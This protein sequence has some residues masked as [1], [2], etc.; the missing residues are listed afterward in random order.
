MHYSKTLKFTDKEYPQ[1]LK[2]VYRPPQ[3]LFYRGNLGIL[4]KPSIAIV[5]T[6]RPT[7]YGEYM[8]EK[9]VKELSVLDVNIVSGLAKGIDTIAHETALECGLSTIAILGSGIENIYPPANIKLAKAIEGNGLVI[10]EFEGSTEPKDF[11]FPMRNRIISGLSLATI[12][13]EAPEKSGALITA[14]YAL[15]QGREIFVIPGDIEREQSLGALRLLQRGAAY[16]IASG[17]EVLEILKT[18]PHL[19]KENLAGN[20]AS[21]RNINSHTK[22]KKTKPPLP[23]ILKNFPREQQKILTALNEFRA[24]TLEYIQEKTQLTAPQLLTH[25]SIL[26]IKNFIKIRDGKYLRA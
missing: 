4:E 25:I 18:Q 20:R 24:K 11:H 16:P 23:E 3:A 8:A 2:Q 14:K 6:R 22:S 15:D 17:Q 10:S 19:F 9:I 26:E 21:N 5:G 7:E 13:I 1:L 12:V